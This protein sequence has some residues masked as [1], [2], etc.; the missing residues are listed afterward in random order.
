ML[1]HAQGKLQKSQKALGDQ[2]HLLKSIQPK[3]RTAMQH[4][5]AYWFCIQMP[6]WFDFFHANCHTPVCLEAWLPALS[7]HR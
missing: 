2:L 4:Y 1:G 6:L 5:C 3:Q 7:I